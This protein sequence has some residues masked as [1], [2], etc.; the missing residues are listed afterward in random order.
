MAYLAIPIKGDDM[1]RD[2][3]DELL[4]F[5]LRPLTFFDIN[6]GYFSAGYARSCVLLESLPRRMCAPALCIS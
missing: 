1:L 3:V 6:H 2:C 4:K 5:L